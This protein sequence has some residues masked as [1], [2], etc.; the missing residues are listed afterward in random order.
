MDHGSGSTNATPSAPIR[1]LRSYTSSRSKSRSSSR[2][3]W[4]GPSTYDPLDAMRTR[5]AAGMNSHHENWATSERWLESDGPKWMGTLG[6]VL[7]EKT[8]VRDRAPDAGLG[9]SDTDWR[10]LSRV[11]G[12]RCCG[13]GA[14]GAR[15]E[16]DLASQ[17]LAATGARPKDHGKGD[18]VSCA[19]D[20]MARRVLAPALAESLPPA[21]VH[22]G[23]RHGAHRVRHRGRVGAAVVRSRNTAGHGRE[24]RGPGN[25]PRGRCTSSPRIA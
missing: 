18:P 7:P 2:D 8:F 19:S 15:P 10:D 14:D 16:D 13:R 25:H 24:H 5:R 1:R 21:L 11:P 9:D 23:R 3:W 20:P 6:N 4:S 12:H 17:A 22:P